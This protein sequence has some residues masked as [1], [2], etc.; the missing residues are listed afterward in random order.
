M[1]LFPSVIE[2]SV[3]WSLMSSLPA[4]D[5]DADC[6]R[7]SVC[8]HL[9]SGLS[10]FT[11]HDA[12]Y[13][14]SNAEYTDTTL[15]DGVCNGESGAAAVEYHQ[16]YSTRIPHRSTFHNVPSV[17]REISSIIEEIHSSIPRSSHVLDIH[18]KRSSAYPE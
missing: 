12:S 4:I 15:E 18:L 2:I 1:G 8:V 16:L 11:V 6:S 14:F 3:V 9:F 17:S 13:T 10:L 5:E 7:C